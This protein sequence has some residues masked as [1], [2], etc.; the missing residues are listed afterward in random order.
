MDVE[1]S[2]QELLDSSRERA[3]SRNPRLIHMDDAIHAI[4][5][6]LAPPE[7]YLLVPVETLEE[8]TG[9]ADAFV[10]THEF[11]RMTKE[12]KMLHV[13]KAQEIIDDYHQGITNVND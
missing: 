10:S 5:A 13:R 1:Q 2:A 8:I 6:A 12:R 3:V 7:G 9:Y 4:I 11:V